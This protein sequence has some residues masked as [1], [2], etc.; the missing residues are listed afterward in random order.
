MVFYGFAEQVRPGMICLIGIHL[1]RL[2]TDI[3][4]G[5]AK[6]EYG[7]RYC[8]VWLRIYGIGVK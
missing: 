5:G 3:F 2:A 4:S 8:I 7:I 6:Q 1:I